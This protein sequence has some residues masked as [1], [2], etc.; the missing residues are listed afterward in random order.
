MTRVMSLGLKVGMFAVELS[1]QCQATSR[2]FHQE[3][4][5]QISNRSSGLLSAAVQSEDVA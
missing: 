3:Q 2:L 1:W 4:S 5:L